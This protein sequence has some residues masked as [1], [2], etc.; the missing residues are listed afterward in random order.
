MPLS[1]HID[2]ENW[3]LITESVASIKEPY[4]TTPVSN[5]AHLPEAVE[6]ANDTF[7]KEY[8]L[9]MIRYRRW[10]NTQRPIH[11]VDCVKVTT[12]MIKRQFRLEGEE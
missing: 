11:Q 8:K 12:K 6:M 3:K 4:P 7:I 1:F 10:L 5:W 2:E 9:L